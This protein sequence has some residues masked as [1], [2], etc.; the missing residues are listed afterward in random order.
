[1][2]YYTNSKALSYYVPFK[3]QSYIYIKHILL[4]RLSDYCLASQQK[5]A[6]ERG[7]FVRDQELND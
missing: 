6:N 1:M 5:H 3:T 2:S 4:R 7:V